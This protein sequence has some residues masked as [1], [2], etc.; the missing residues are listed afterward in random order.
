L[1]LPVLGTLLYHIATSKQSIMEEF[2]DNFYNPCFIKTS[3]IDVYYE[4][5]N[6]GESPKSLYASIKCNYIKCNIVNALK[7]INNSIYIIGGHE[8]ENIN[9]IIREYQTYNPAIEASL[10][11]NSKY[12]PQL[13]N[14]SELYHVILM[15]FL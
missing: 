13:E 8:M 14:P 11:G 4:S 2:A 6:L 3:L 12:L 5:A 7:K 15:L 1:D 10:I 9:E